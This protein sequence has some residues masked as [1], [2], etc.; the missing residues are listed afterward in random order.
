MPEIAKTSAGQPQTG[1]GM[2][3]LGFGTYGRTG[4]GG[5]AQLVTAFETGYR[6]F[7]TAQ[8]YNT[9]REVG[10]AVRQSGLPRNKIFIT[11]KVA[12]TN[13]SNY[14]VVES[15]EK[16]L[17]IL[18]MDHV[19]LALIH[20]PSPNGE[21]P[22]AVYLDQMLEA[23]SKNLAK[24]IGVS[25]FTIALLDE[26]ISRAG[27][28]VIVNNQVELN[29]WLQ[30]RKLANHCKNKGV[31]VTCYCP[32]L[33]GQLRSDSVLS[34]IASA[35]KATVEQVALA[36]EISQGYTAI[37]TSSKTDRI[38]SNF[39]ALN[40]RLSPTNVSDILTCDRGHRTIDPSWGP[41]WD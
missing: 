9:E 31:S 12:T 1:F 38:R 26:A 15:L 39:A 27:P 36:F 16:S 17:N 3:L 24:N 35:H 5:I 7:D 33:R 2:P 30:N 18:Q 37:P 4:T 40:L 29:P 13:L 41:E 14:K 21:L 23:K 22:L 20:W 11:T 8:D 28:G 19:D 32:I 34:R 25:N 6:H 10:I